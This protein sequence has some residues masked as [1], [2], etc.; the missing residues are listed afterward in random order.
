MHTAYRI[1]IAAVLVETILSSNTSAEAADRCCCPSVLMIRG[2]LGYWPRAQRLEGHIRCHGYRTKISRCAQVRKAAHYIQQH[3]GGEPIIIV[4]YSLG[5]DSAC[6]VCR[7][8]QEAGIRVDTLILIESTLGV[9]VPGNVR[10]CINLYKSNPRRDWLPAFRGVPVVAEGC[11]QLKN[12]DVRY[13]PQLAYISQYEH[14]TMA[15]AW[16]V[17]KLVVQLINGRHTCCQPSTP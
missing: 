15:T 5:A 1:L 9:S 16:D 4:G 2:A 13:T 7:R 3:H 11:T 10:S 14:M 8:L 12:V 17:Q 6:W